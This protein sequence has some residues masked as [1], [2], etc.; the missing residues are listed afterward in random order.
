MTQMKKLAMLVV[1]TGMLWAGLGSGVREAW[2]VQCGIGCPAGYHPETYYCDAA[3]GLCVNVCAQ[4]SVCQPNG[5]SFT[6]CGD[7]PAGYRTSSRWCNP[8]CLVCGAS[9]FG[10]TNSGTCTKI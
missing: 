9:C 4:A 10:L 5:N 3:C 1:L 8:S 2:A 7:C 6:T